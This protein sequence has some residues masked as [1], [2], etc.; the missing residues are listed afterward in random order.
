MVMAK[1]MAMGA[2]PSMAASGGSGGDGPATKTGGMAGMDMGA[3]LADV[4]YDAFLLN[5]ASQADPW[6]GVARPGE[7]VRL[8]V[9]N[10]AASTFMRFM[11][12]G[13]GLTVVSAD[14]A[15]IEPVETDNIL[16][17][18]A[19][20]YDVVVTVK[21]SG[22]FTIRAESQDGSGQALGV[23]HTPDA[24]P[25]ADPGKPKWGPRRLSYA[26]LRAPE[27]TTLP[28]GPDRAYDLALTGDMAKY[29]WSIGGQVFPDADPLIVSPGERVRVRLINKT[30]MW[31]P[32]HLHGHYFRLLGHTDGDRLAPRKHTVS[33]APRETVE[34]EFLADNPGAWFFHCHNAYH[35][36]AGMARV[37]RY[38]A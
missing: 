22:S 29:V 17:G 21:E 37:W 3:D 9:I 14:G 20:T 5:G 6:A 28:D 34:I 4:T 11:V 16:L 35:L 18:V 25:V 33:L 30:G 13:H 26:E 10:A 15:E 7:R 19:E 31:H 38:M 24:T 2:M 32:M 23:L 8:R 36:E 12:D 27:E 1:G